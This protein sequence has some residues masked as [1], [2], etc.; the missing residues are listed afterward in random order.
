MTRSGTFWLITLAILLVILLLSSAVQK[1]FWEDETLTAHTAAG[2][3][4]RISQ[5]AKRDMHPPL[6][7]IVASYWGRL[8]GY[9]ELGL[10]SLSIIFAVLTLVFAYLFASEAFEQRTAIFAIIL[11]AISPLFIMYAHNAR[12]YS[13]SAFLT[14]LA[15]YA[16]YRFESSNRFIYLF[17]Y[18]AAC[19]ALL[20]LIFL[21][22]S[23]F[24]ACN[25]W[26]FIQWWRKGSH[27]FS[28]VVYWLSAQA[29]VFVLFTVGS[30]YLL[31]AI[32]NYPNDIEFQNWLFDI[33]KRIAFFG[34]SFSVGETISPT[35]PIAWIGLLVV[36]GIAV[37]ALW[38]NR[39]NINFWLLVIMVML[40]LILNLVASFNARLISTW[41]NISYRSLFALPFFL[42]WLG[43]GISKM[44]PNV[45]L[46]ITFILVLV[47]GVGLF[48]YFSNNQY[49]RPMFTVNWHE[50][51]Q[52]IYSNAQADTVV[53][54]NRGDYSCFYY[55]QRYELD[56]YRSNNWED[57]K[58]DDPSEV[59]WVQTNLIREI[60]SEAQENTVFNNIS[61]Q[62]VQS[63]TFNY[64]PQD[65]SIRDFKSRFLNLRE[66]EYRVNV[67]RFYNP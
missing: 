5:L 52:N 35:N 46:V 64:A 62:Y 45:G 32:Q 34:Y 58:K 31:N 8:F 63:E 15:V 7:Y 1:S 65:S 16:M 49:I 48:N 27:K 13:F 42:I 55:S 66:Y 26:W 37:F 24:L 9:N 2:G 54:C 14:I 53:I 51:F 44:R 41:Q 60:E 17:V 12:Y 4:E 10:R 20:Y 47:H 29:A 22:I 33:L 25:I 19:T 11:L 39:K 50:I 61:K 6:M 38:I 3:L 18:I 43:T 23:V 56:T 40:I 36:I 21:S 28:Q 57:I 30:R 59:W 67:I